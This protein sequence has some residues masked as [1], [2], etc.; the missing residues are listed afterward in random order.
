MGVSRSGIHPPGSLYQYQNEWVAAKGVCI[1]M[2]TKGLISYL[3]AE[4]A[5]IEDG[6]GI[7]REKMRTGENAFAI[8]NIF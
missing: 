6:R 1:N 3:V 5:M 7:A 4:D 8:H 2:K